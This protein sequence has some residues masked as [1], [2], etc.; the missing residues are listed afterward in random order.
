MITEAIWED[1]KWTKGS[2]RTDIRKFITQN[3]DVDEDKI[4]ENLSTNLSKMVD[5]DSKSGYPC[6]RKVENNYKLTPEWR[7]EWKKK[8]GIRPQRRMKKK[9][10]DAPKHPRNSYLWYL[11]DVRE[12]LKEKYPDKDH[13]EI[14]IMVADEWKHLPPKKKKKYE[15]KA[16]EDKER[17]EREM[18]A[19]KKRKKQK[20]ETSDESSSESKSKSKKKKRRIESESE[21]GK[22]DTRTKSKRRKKDSDSDSSGSDK[23][24]KNTK[25]R[26][27]KADES[28]ESGSKGGDKKPDSIKKDDP[29]K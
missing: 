8:A 5:T 26:T 21:S 2:S 1:K 22:S 7:K 29:K 3:Y 23:K 24:K 6:L 25:P 17:Y 11:Q 4:K 19:Y 20:R 15:D 16:L 14:T 9:D 27:R 18:K 28:S 10:K 13:R 12:S